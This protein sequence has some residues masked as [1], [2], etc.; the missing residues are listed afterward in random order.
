[1][2]EE[3][4]LDDFDEMGAGTTVTWK[5]ILAAI[6]PFILFGSTFVLEGMDYHDS[7]PPGPTWPI[8]RYWQWAVLA[9]LLVGLGVGWARNFPRWSYAYLGAVLMG[10]TG[11][12]S[13]ASFGLELLGF[14]FGREQRVWLDWMPLLLL[15]LIMLLLTRSLRPLAR[16]F[17]GMQ[18]DWTRLSFVLYTMFCWL[19][20]V[21]TYDGKTWYLQ[22]QYLPLNL[23][24]VTLVFA[25][26]AF[27]YMRVHRPWPRALVLQ[28]ALFL[29]GLPSSAVI[30]ASASSA[31]SGSPFTADRWLLFTFIWLMYSSI[32]LIPGLARQAW[33]RIRPTKG[34]ALRS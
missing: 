8:T 5:E 18:R 20:L 17:E 25:G 27:F 3:N 28:A 15:A 32:P 13:A 12:A 33:L 9:G 10:S 16:L 29:H 26:G 2:L 11:L 23:L 19:I 34:F 22:T 30:P 4:Q 7:R 24:L 1:M 31:D 14:T 6:L 21:V